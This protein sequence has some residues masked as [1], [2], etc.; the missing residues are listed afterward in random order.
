MKVKSI[1]I[2]ATIAVLGTNMLVATPAEA[3]PHCMYWAHDFSGKRVADGSAWAK[4]MRLACKRAKRRCNRELKRKK[5]RGK[6]GRV[7][8]KRVTEAKG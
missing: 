1:A 3:R 6:V 4:N 2:A 5:R 7:S 8:C